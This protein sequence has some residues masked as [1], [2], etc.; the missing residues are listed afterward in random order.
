VTEPDILIEKVSELTWSPAGKPKSNISVHQ[1]LNLIQKCNMRTIEFIENRD[2]GKEKKQC[3]VIN[4]V[5]TEKENET[6]VPIEV[7][8]RLKN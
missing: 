4:K 3:Y 5:P 1:A 7:L 6:H 2:A 8:Q